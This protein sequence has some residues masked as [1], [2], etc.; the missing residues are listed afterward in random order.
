M[1]Q[2]LEA[3]SKELLWRVKDDGLFYCST[4]GFIVQISSAGWKRIA[5]MAVGIPMPSSSVQIQSALQ[6][7]RVVIRTVQTRQPQQ[8]WIFPL[9]AGLT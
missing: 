1:A 9:A 4:C 2:R 7:Q 8:R 6:P 3:D 5:P